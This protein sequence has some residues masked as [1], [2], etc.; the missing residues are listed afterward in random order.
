[1]RAIYR[2]HAGGVSIARL[3]SRQC[4]LTDASNRRFGTLARQ[5]MLWGTVN[6][7]VTLMVV[8]AVAGATSWL[9]H[10]RAS[11]ERE[12]QLAEDRKQWQAVDSTLRGIWKAVSASFRATI[13]SPTAP[14]L[15]V[16]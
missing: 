14:L 13:I 2:R 15:Q 11:R 1:M 6:L 3:R 16:A 9:L 7:H 8:L 10:Y 12:L 4:E 5:G